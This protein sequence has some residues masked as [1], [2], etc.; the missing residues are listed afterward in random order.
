V[1]ALI[2]LLAGCPPFVAYV[3]ATGGRVTSI[4]YQ[5]CIPEGVSEPLAIR[6]RIGAS[7]NAGLT[8]ASGRISEWKTEA[9]QMVLEGKIHYESDRLLVK[10]P[11]ET[12]GTQSRIITYRIVPSASSA[13]TR[14]TTP[15]DLGY[16][17]FA[18]S[19]SEYDAYRPLQRAEVANA[20]RVRWLAEKSGDERER[21]AKQTQIPGC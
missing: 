11:P 5:V 8:G 14:W 3:P 9:G 21:Y 4:I 15:L 16:G 13:W 18:R 19:I 2:V 12:P 10:M 17:D 20:P 7:Y 6:P 1:V